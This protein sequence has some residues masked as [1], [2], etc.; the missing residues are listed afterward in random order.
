MLTAVTF[1]TLLY[2]RDLEETNFVRS[3]LSKYLEF[4]SVANIGCESDI[5]SVFVCVTAFTC[6]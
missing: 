1:F 5:G 4:A 6:L 2:Q 3:I